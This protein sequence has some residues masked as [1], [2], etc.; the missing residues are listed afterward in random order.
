ME[1]DLKKYYKK[2]YQ[3]AKIIYLKLQK[4]GYITRFRNIWHLPENGFLSEASYQKWQG[5]FLIK[6]TNIL[7]I[8]V[9]I[10]I[11]LNMAKAYQN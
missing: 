4:S 6:R 5:E 10:K 11:V 8:I 7:I 9:R 2:G 3:D 1:I